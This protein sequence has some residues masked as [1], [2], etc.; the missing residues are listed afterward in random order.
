MYGNAHNTNAID[1][2]EG[3]VV[4][5]D[6]MLMEARAYTLAPITV[7]HFLTKGRHSGKSK[8]QLSGHPT[9]GDRQWR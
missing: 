6:V 4:G 9:C 1:Y 3:A 5:R 2:A 8:Q 7:R